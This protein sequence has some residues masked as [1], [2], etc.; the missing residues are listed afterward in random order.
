MARIK[1]APHHPQQQQPSM[2]LIRA[3][4]LFVS[5]MFVVFLLKQADVFTRTTTSSPNH[6][7]QQQ[8]RK[9]AAGSSKLR[10]RGHAPSQKQ[11]DKIASLVE[12]SSASDSTKR[13]RIALDLAL[14]KQGSG[15]SSTTSGTIVL[16]LVEEWAP[17][18][19]EHFQKLMEAKFYDQVRFFRVLPNFVAQFGIS[20]DPAVQR[21]WKKQTLVDD[22]VLH[23]NE[24]GTITYAT[25]GPNTRTTQL[26]INL[27]DNKYLDDEG[28]APFARIVSGL[29]LIDQI[30]DKYREQPAQGQ[31]QQRGNEYLQENFPDLSYVGAARIL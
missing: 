22:P 17:I 31:I 9:T 15:E 25:S 1:K 6:G 5:L 29:E 11:K 13:P 19:V 14:L 2:Q 23:P 18:G 3:V 12:S 10:I 4:I 7:R 16:E 24:R 8:P 21:Q 30:Q 20:G 26:F 27:K 28:F